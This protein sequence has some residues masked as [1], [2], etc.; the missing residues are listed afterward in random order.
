MTEI[1]F[2]PLTARSIEYC[3][4]SGL[5]RFDPG[6]QGEHKIQRGFEPILTYSN[7]WIVDERLRDAVARFAAQESEQVRAYQRE[8]STLLPFKQEG[9]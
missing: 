6:A 7:H 9:V 3:I 4:A 1:V 5:T 2:S 8:A